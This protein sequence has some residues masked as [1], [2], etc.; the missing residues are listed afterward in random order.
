[1]LLDYGV[2]IVD[3]TTRQDED[4]EFIMQMPNPW[5][6]KANGRPVYCVQLRLWQDDASG[7]R[8]KQWNKHWLVCVTHAGIPKRLQAQEYFTRFYSCSPHA[9]VLEQGGAFVQEIKCVEL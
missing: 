5:R 7:N 3:D 6:K 9:S 4:R 2:Y 8:S 1:M